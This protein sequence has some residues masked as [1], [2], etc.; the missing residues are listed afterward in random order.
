[1]FSNLRKRE[2]FCYSLHTRYVLVTRK[3]DFYIKKPHGLIT[4]GRIL[5]QIY[6]IQKYLNIKMR[7]YFFGNIF[8]GMSYNSFYN[9]IVYLS[10]S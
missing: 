3:S 7:I 10:K 4:T 6:S 9:L 5:Y 2:Y 1:M 8:S